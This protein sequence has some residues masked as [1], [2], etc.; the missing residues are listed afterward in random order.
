MAFTRFKYDTARVNRQLE[1]ETFTGRYMLGTPGNG[2]DMPFN[3]DPHIRLQRWGANFCS[4]ALE[5][6]NDLMGLNR[7]PS[8][9]LVR[10]S[11]ETTAA[12]YRPNTYKTASTNV[13]HSRLDHPAWEIRGFQSS[14]DQSLFI[15]PQNH[16]NIPFHNN[17]S[18]RILE[19]DAYCV[20]LNNR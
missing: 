9:D 16:V 19:K 7:T 20:G 5:I 6:E 1:V 3:E 11:Y 18:T 15:N 12:P 13:V 14:R 17:L 10:H 4:N 2:T 8:K